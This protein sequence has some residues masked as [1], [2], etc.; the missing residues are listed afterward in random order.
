MT[1]LRLISVIRRQAYYRPM[2]AALTACGIDQ[3]AIVPPKGRG[4]PILEMVING[5][6]HRLPIP[7]SPSGGS[8][9]SHYI[10]AEIRRLARRARA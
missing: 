5:Q 10:P 4:H 8:E 3:F 6:S 7:G 9:A 1:K 2:L